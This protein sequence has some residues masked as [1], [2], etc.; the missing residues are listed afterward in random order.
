MSNMMAR[1]GMPFV[2]VSKKKKKIARLSFLGSYGHRRSRPRRQWH[3]HCDRYSARRAIQAYR[4]APYIRGFACRSSWGLTSCPIPVP[5][6]M[7]L[8]SNCIEEAGPTNTG[9]GGVS[10]GTPIHTALALAGRG[11][12]APALRDFATELCVLPRLLHAQHLVG[13]AG[14]WAGHGFRWP[15]AARLA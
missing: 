2:R 13:P 11:K 9:R 14:G 1:I 10:V 6:A 8:Y 15:Q 12:Q 4:N 7:G 3:W 5:A